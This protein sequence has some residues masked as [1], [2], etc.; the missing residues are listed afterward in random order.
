MVATICKI[1]RVVKLMCFTHSQTCD[2]YGVL[3]PIAKLTPEQV[4]YHFIS[5]YTSKMVGTEV[6]ISTPT[7]TFSSCY[8]APFLALH[9]YVY[10][11][12]LAEKL[13]KHSAKAWLINTG[14][15]G[16]SACG[17]GRRCPLRYTRRILDAVHNGSLSSP[18]TQYETS[19]AFK[20]EIPLTVEGV[21]KEILA[22]CRS[23]ANPEGYRKCVVE[24]AKLFVDNFVQYMD[25]CPPEVLKAGPQLDGL[26]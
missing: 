13:R 21:P 11:S 5:G 17:T 22:P 4:V 2:A 24:L 3:P 7:A 10:A 12:M 18:S 23:W 26:L 25:K 1:S 14:W 6:G 15:I 8:A 19:T 9:P 20:F 16:G